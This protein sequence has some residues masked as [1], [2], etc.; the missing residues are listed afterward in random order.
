MAADVF[1]RKETLVCREKTV[2]I[3][4][5]V[6]LLCSFAPSNRLLEH[7]SLPPLSYN[8]QL[9]SFK[10]ILL[11]KNVKKNKQT[12]MSRRNVL[13]GMPRYHDMNKMEIALLDK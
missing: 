5:S 7:L 6:P 11:F 4:E 2:I 1:K 13:Q 10:T 8:A 12:T 3:K 9:P